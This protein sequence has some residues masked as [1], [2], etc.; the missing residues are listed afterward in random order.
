LGLSAL[1]IGRAFGHGQAPTFIREGDSPEAA[2]TP[3]DRA[4]AIWAFA[5]LAA[6]VPAGIA[7]LRLWLR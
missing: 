6:I 3:S 4:M 1:W 2:F 7:G 5:C